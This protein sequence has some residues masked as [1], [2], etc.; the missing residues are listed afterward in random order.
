MHIKKTTSHKTKQTKAKKQK[1]KKH[2]ETKTNNITNIPRFKKNLS[3]TIQRN[4]NSKP[5]FF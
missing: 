1:P 2:N 4:G 5:V 3:N